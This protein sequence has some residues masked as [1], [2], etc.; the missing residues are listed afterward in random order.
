M[1]SNHKITFLLLCLLVECALLKGE[2]VRML[3][4]K[5]MQID[6]IFCLDA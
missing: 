6:H 5:A 3:G 4:F 1:F 2:K